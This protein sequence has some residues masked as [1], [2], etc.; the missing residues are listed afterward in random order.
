[1]PPELYCI[2]RSQ[3]DLVQGGAGAQFPAASL[4]VLALLRQFHP[5][6]LWEAQ[7]VRE[8]IESHQGGIWAAIKLRSARVLCYSC[9]LNTLRRPCQTSPRDSSNSFQCSHYEG[10][11]CFFSSTS[12]CLPSSAHYPSKKVRGRGTELQLQLLRRRYGGP[13]S[14]AASKARGRTGV[15]MGWLEWLPLDERL[16]AM[17]FVVLGRE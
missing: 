1:M 15:V 9:L 14:D 17:H 5:L 10:S 11:R 3:L 8:Y 13:C 12:P 7:R 6:Q 4:S 2:R 16:T